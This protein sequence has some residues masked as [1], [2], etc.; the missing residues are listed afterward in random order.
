MSLN[1]TVSAWLEKFSTALTAKDAGAATALFADECYWRDLVA[2][3]WNHKTLEG[4]T[5]IVDMLEHALDDVQPSNWQCYGE[6]TGTE[7]LT[8]SWI[9]FDTAVARGKGYLRLKHGK[10]FT[11]LTTMVELKGHEEKRVPLALRARSM[12][13]I[14]T[15]KTGQRCARAR[16][17][18]LALKRSLIA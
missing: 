2:F 17:A 18:S 15:A 12:A 8:E 1:E 6:A 10:C 16:N 3:T 7:A 4:K 14:S 5:A 11:L 9:T 13:F